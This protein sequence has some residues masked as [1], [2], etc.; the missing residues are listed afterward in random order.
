[1]EFNP[2]AMSFAELTQTPLT[3]A[4]ISAYG[5]AIPGLQA[6]FQ[7]GVSQMTQPQKGMGM[8]DKMA[9]FKQLAAGLQGMGQRPQMPQ[10]S[11]QIM[12]DNNRFTYANNPQQQMAQA[13]RNRG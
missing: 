4:A 8:A 7:N 1:M 9:M 6:Q 2:N 3:N 5:A 10:N 11:V 13:L 12:H